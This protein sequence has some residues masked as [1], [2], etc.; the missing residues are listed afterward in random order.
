MFASG[1][2]NWRIGE[3]VNWRVKII[4]NHQLTQNLIL[5]TNSS[6][7]IFNLFIENIYL[8]GYNPFAHGHQ[9]YR[10]SSSF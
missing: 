10:Q 7:F 8:C 3:L 5:N 9:G 2:I 1:Q 4:F 6:F